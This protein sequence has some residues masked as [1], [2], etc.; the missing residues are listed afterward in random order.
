ML[1]CYKSNNANSQMNLNQIMAHPV[2]LAVILT[3]MSVLTLIA[4][5][6]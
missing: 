3:L 6:H 4:A 2:R 5:V 1:Y